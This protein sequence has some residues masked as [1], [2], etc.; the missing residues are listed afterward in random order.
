MGEPC[1]GHHRKG[2]RGYGGDHSSTKK[3]SAATTVTD[4]FTTFEDIVYRPIQSEVGSG[5]AHR[6]VEVAVN[7]TL[8]STTSRTEP[9]EATAVRGHATR[10][11]RLAARNHEPHLIMFW[12]VSDGRDAPT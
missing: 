1:R 9:P 8:P 5:L 11:S 10:H 2:G 7:D 4:P 3:I 12:Q 6:L